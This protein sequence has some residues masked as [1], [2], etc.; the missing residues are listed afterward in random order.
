MVK[1]ENTRPSK[2]RGLRA[3]RVR[4][5]LAARRGDG[6][7]E[8]VRL[9]IGFVGVAAVIAAVREWRIRGLEKQF[10]PDRTS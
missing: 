3:L 1:S 2:G 7:G 9:L 4:A 8:R 5:P 10:D 6:Y